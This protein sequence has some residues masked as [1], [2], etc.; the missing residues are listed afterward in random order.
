M[1]F[2][3]EK[4][5]KNYRFVINKPLLALILFI[6]LVVGFAIFSWE[7]GFFS[8]IGKQGAIPTPEHVENS[9]SD[10]KSLENPESSKKKGS[11]AK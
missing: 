5:E 4:A 3:L 11:E 9:A 6:L 7:A 2:D 1:D 10:Q 8:E